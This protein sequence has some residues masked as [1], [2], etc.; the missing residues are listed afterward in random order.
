MGAIKKQPIKSRESIDYSFPQ[1]PQQQ[2]QQNFNNSQLFQQNGRINN[3]PKDFYLPPL[4]QNFDKV[5][6]VAN[7]GIKIMV[8][9]RG[10]PGSGKSY[11]GREI[12]NKT[13][14]GDYPNH[15]FSAD[16]YFLNERGQYNYVPDRIKNAHEFNQNRVRKKC[17][18]GWSPIIVDNTHIK[19]WEMF[20]YCYSAVQNGYFIEICEPVTPWS[21]SPA[22]LAMK[23]SHGVPRNVIENMIQN[24][25]NINC[26]NLLKAIKCER[27][28]NLQPQQRNYPLII[29]R[30]FEENN[31]LEET[32]KP[33]IIQQQQIDPVQEVVNSEFQMHEREKIN[34]WAPIEPIL[35]PIKTEWESYEKE[36]DKFWRTEPTTTTT[37]TVPN[38][39]VPRLQRFEK[40]NIPLVNNIYTV[41]PDES[42]NLPDEEQMNEEV[43]EEQQ[44]SPV[45][46]EQHKFGCCNENSSFSGIRQ[47]YPSVPVEYLWDL[48]VTCQGDGDWTMDILLKEEAKIVEFMQTQ[49]SAMQLKNDFN[50]ECEG[51]GAGETTA[52]NDLIYL[53][54][55]FVEVKIFF[56]LFNDA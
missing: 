21:R 48:F 17:E 54:D 30:K 7:Q 44:A 27:H 41:L 38:Q 20:P 55:E 12:I 4:C 15:I 1:P 37:T 43:P 16:D 11:L 5:V 28:L 51:V 35:N 46:L 47:I 29:Q 50:C 34:F 9:L 24:Y 18:D 52:F 26:F 36:K 49:G 13:V 33:Q 31:F 3:N 8:I 10:P 40:P 25:E 56:Y 14:N 23:N 39:R 32:L 2:Q 53:G 19:I 22:K 45:I 42:E 6:H